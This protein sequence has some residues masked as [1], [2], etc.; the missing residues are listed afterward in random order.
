[1][2]EYTPEISI[3][4][5][6]LWADVRD[7]FASK[8][9]I[10]RWE[11][12]AI[13]HTEKADVPVRKI[14]HW[15]EN[16]DYYANVGASSHIKF[17]MGL[18][19]YEF[20][21]YPFRSHLEVTVKIIPIADSGSEIIE[22]A[23]VQRFKA[24]FPPDKN[25][26]VI[27]GKDGMHDARGLNQ[28]QFVDVL[29]ELQDRALEP[30]RRK[31]TSDSFRELSVERLIRSLMYC[32]SRN[33]LVDG[34]PAIDGVEMDTPDND[35]IQSEIVIPDGTLLSN[36]PTW[37]QEKGA[38]V[39]STAIGT[40]FQRYDGRNLWFIFPIY[41]FTKFDT[42]KKKLIIFNVPNGRYNGTDKS[43]KVEGNVI[44]IVSTNGSEIKDEAGN[45]ELNKGFGFRMVNAKSVMRKP[46]KVIKGVATYSRS[47]TVMEVGY[48]DR[49]DGL[50]YAPVTKPTGNPFAEY[51]KILPSHSIHLTAIWENA[52][53]TLLFPGMAI[54]YVYLMHG[55]Y[56]ELRGCLTGVFINRTL[57]GRAGTAS[58]YTT[59]ATLG[60]ILESKDEVYDLPTPPSTDA[61]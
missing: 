42:A 15:E 6:P 60:M 2:S 22:E 50:H 17:D 41:R 27:A 52:D 58:V 18:G 44:K 57:Q 1:M 48:Q 39:Y 51:S 8:K 40:F 19:D 4:N 21:L 31:M 25:P 38:G 9:S 37:C 7:I 26:I 55:K 29:L 46:V 45:S 49:K 43:Y 14:L 34:K 11:Y 12:R 53:P 56:V 36:L 54:K 24:I 5:S 10:S 16:R 30:L 61:F 28:A 20:F 23:I 13:L 33:I 3:E 35:E 59:H 47:Q 32:E